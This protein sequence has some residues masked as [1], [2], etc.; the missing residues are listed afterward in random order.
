MKDEAFSGCFFKEL[1]SMASVAHYLA[2]ASAELSLTDQFEIRDQTDNTVAKLYDEVM[3]HL[4]F[5][6][7]ARNNHWRSEFLDN[8]LTDRP[9]EFRCHTLVGMDVRMTAHEYSGGLDECSPCILSVETVELG[10]IYE[11]YCRYLIR[12]NN[13]QKALSIYCDGPSTPT[14]RLLSEVENA[15]K[16]STKDNLRI[17]GCLRKTIINDLGALRMNPD[18]PWASVRA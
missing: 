2:L 15:I 9:R 16:I 7:N 5:M 4:S 18:D 12:K 10:D 6:K 17:L 1:F 3:R 11:S 14:T 8:I 13:F